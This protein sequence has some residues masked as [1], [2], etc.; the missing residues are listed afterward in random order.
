MRSVSHS[1]RGDRD[2]EPRR[3]RATRSSAG[4][5]DVWLDDSEIRLR[6][7]SRS[8]SSSESILE[9]RVLVCCGRPW[10]ARGALGGSS[11]CSVQNRLVSCA[12]RHR[13]AVVTCGRPSSGHDARRRGRA[14]AGARDP[15][16]RR[17]ARRPVDAAAARGVGPSRRADRR[18]RRG[19]QDDDRPPG[20]GK[21]PRRRRAASK[22]SAKH[23]LTSV[24]PPDG[25]V[26]STRWAI[27]PTSGRPS[28]RPGLSWR[29]A[30]PPPRS[31]DREL[32]PVG[33]ECGLRR[34]PRRPA[35]RGSRARRRW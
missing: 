21:W 18:Q 5:L 15:R 25:A 17:R 1:R 34:R 10:R 2:A 13:A 4:G 23:M 35:C 33:P 6:R 22:S 16:R 28:P 32:E 3:P 29:G 14:A 11:G 7:P 30:M 8:L 27:R 24:P 31:A 20:R 9:C 19:Q 26:M 12:R